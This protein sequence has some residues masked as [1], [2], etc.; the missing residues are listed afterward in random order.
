M[1]SLQ[2]FTGV[3]ENCIWKLLR[4]TRLVKPIFGKFEGC[5]SK[6]L[7]E[8]YLVTGAFGSLGM[9]G[10]FCCKH[11]LVIFWAFNPQGT[12]SKVLIFST[13]ISL[14]RFFSI[15]KIFRAYKKSYSSASNF[16]LRC[17]CFSSA[18]FLLSL[19][20]RMV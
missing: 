19:K 5:K 9:C 16:S 7:L 18:L 11:F 17:F 4:K 20:D 2:V 1:F 6:T 8:M 15:F 12:I 14:S 13:V 3:R 10:V